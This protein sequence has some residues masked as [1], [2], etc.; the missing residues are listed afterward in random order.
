[1]KEVLI[2]ADRCL[3]CRSCQIACAVEHSASKNLFGAIA[4]SPVPRYRL[5]VEKADGLNIPLTCRHCDPAP[6]AEACI[7]GSI[8]KDARGAVV[9]KEDRCIGCWTC[10]MVCPYGVVGS[11]LDEKVAVKC[12]RCP[13]REI[14]ACVGACPTKALLFAE[15]DEFAAATRKSRAGVLVGTLLE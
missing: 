12:D 7:A 6:C 2:R 9:Q 4:E 14:P 13:D 15:V 1:M 10:V 11:R 8:T 3:G 5:F